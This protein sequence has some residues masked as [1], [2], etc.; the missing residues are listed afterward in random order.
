MSGAQDLVAQWVEGRARTAF[1][2]GEGGR[3]CGT[4]IVEPGEPIAQLE[5]GA[6]W[7]REFGPTAVELRSARHA[8]WRRF[9]VRSGK[10]EVA[11]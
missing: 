1:F 11:T 7:L 9:S 8:D 4:V 10:I 6:E 2:T 3:W 5:A